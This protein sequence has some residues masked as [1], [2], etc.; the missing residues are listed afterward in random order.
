MF[1]EVSYREFQRHHGGDPEPP[2]I[3]TRAYKAGSYI[4]C[5]LCWTQ[6]ASKAIHEGA[7]SYIISLLCMSKEMKQV[8]KKHS[9]ILD[10]S[11]YC[12]VD[13]VKSTQHRIKHIKCTYVER[14]KS[15]FDLHCRS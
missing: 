5:S 13:R 11:I 15:K 6:G 9:N 8:I 14:V 4:K 12:H 3:S 1:R 7:K 2:A 10:I